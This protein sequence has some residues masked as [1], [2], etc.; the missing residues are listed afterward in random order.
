[1]FLSS[2]PILWHQFESNGFFS[3]I[4]T[5]IQVFGVDVVAG[6][7]YIHSQGVLY[8]DLKPSN[9]LID[10]HGVLK[11]LC[12]SMPYRFILDSGLAPRASRFVTLLPQLCDFRLSQ[13]VPGTSSKESGG[14]VRATHR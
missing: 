4:S 6:L 10:E 5:S 13:R 7:Q 1:M 12:P 9:T 14:H 3:S 11:V 2:I 8:C